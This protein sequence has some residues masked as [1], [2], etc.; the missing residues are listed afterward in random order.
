[1]NHSCGAYFYQGSCPY[2]R[3]RELNRMCGC[4]PGVLAK[5]FPPATVSAANPAAAA[6][7][8]A[9]ANLPAAAAADPRAGL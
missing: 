9:A 3:L 7:R 2:N 8:P 6:N 1:M 4:A 5:T